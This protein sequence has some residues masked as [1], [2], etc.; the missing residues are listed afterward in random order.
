ML[1]NLQLVGRDY[2]DPL[3]KVCIV[4]LLIIFLIFNWYFKINNFHTRTV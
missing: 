4:I 2:F 1:L 3:A